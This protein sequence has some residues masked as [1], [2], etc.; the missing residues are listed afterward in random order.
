[1]RSGDPSVNDTV[2]DSVNDTVTVSRNETVTD[3]HPDPEPHL[4]SKSLEASD[5]GGCPLLRGRHALKIGAFWL[6]RLP[7][8]CNVLRDYQH[9]LI[10]KARDA[11]EAGCTRLLM[12]APT[13]AGK[14]H[15]IAALV[16]AADTA[17]L[18]VLV[19]A[20]RSRLIRQLHERLDAFG[21]DH[22]V[23]AAS[24]PQWSNFM[25]PVQ[26]ASADTLFRRCIVDE[27]S[28]LPSAEI[29]IF[30]EAHLS[31]GA[32]RVRL[33]DAYPNAILFG[34]TAT[35]AKTSGRAL[36]A[37]YDTLIDGPTVNELITLGAL[38]R[39]RIFAAPALSGAELRGVSVSSSSGDYATGELS[40]AM[41]RPRIVGDVVAT[42]LRLAAGKR[43]LVFACD[44]AHGQALVEEFLRAGVSAELLTDVDDESTREAAIARLEAGE[45]RVLVNCFL[46]SY[47]IDIPSVE[48][49]VLARPTRS[50]VLYLQAIGRGMRAAPGKDSVIVLD[51]GR[52]VESLG[53]P[54]ADL[55]WTLDSND[56]VNSR[57][58]AVNRR[59]LTAE[60][61]RT[62]KECGHMWAVREQGSSC[63]ECGWAPAPI[64][65]QVIVEAGELEEVG[66]AHAS[67][68]EGGELEA[69]LAE[70]CGFYATR[71]PDR[72]RE[73]PNSGRWW[74]W[75]QAVERLG[76][77]GRH[78]PS[79]L[80]RCVPVQPS[81][82][83]AGWLKSRLIA[84]AKSKG[85]RR[86]A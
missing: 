21:V 35:P 45:T 49:V 11:I 50:V 65:R 66:A 56:N 34:L 26:V 58:A 19:I 84:W 40:Q 80:W 59:R 9:A 16:A 43:T 17:Q 31:L 51:H 39:A 28:P 63:P 42:W 7:A 68:V 70:A 72:W 14:T 38:V 81:T 55:A 79:T 30:D 77:D 32:S 1:M 78:A 64:G 86:V 5:G 25:L 76:L 46:L 44:K 8:T 29:V 83:T 12:Q 18:R 23:I 41:C 54:T 73:K 48:C 53:M 82:E 3:T 24:F 74:A 6:A 75:Q 52:V 20:T 15:V 62:C 69:F 10:A 57:A 37:M 36:G 4:R 27:R 67:E 33:L 71:W 60:N 47:G 85:S 13:G 2:T 61:A 22:G